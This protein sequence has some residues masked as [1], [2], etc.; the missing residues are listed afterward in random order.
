MK[1]KNFLVLN[2]SL[3]NVHSYYSLKTS[4]NEFK[5]NQGCSQTIKM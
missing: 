2:K 4:E 5:K 1:S 3:N